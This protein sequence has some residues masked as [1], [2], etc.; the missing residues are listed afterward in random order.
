M[1]VLQMTFSLFF[2]FSLIVLGYSSI[3]TFSENT[4]LD[5]RQVSFTNVTYQAGFQDVGGQFLAWGDYNNDGYQDILVNG[6]RLFE[7]NGPPN[8]DF[9]EVT[10]SVG[11]TGGS[12]G[13]WADWDNDGLLDFYCAGS[14]K[15]YKNN[16]PPD[17]DFTDVTTSSGILK[18]S[19]STGC[20]WGDYDNDGDVDLF[21][22]RGEDGSTGEYFPNSFWR[23]NG[24]GTF[25]NVTVE[26]GVDE[27][28][29]PTYSRGVAWADFN[30]DG[31]LDVYISNYRQLP[32]YLYQ[33]N[34]NGTFTEVAAQ[35]NV[36]DGPPLDEGNLDPYDRA[37]H[38]VGSVW[39]DYDNDGFLDLWV[40]NLNHK[41]ART[42]DDSL[43]YHNDG[44]PNY[45][46]TNMRGS[47]G[48]PVKPYVFPNEGDELFVGCAWG[49]YDNDGDL[50]LYLPQIYDIDYAYSFLYSN[51]GDGT[52]TDVTEEA[53]VQVWDT[54]A[55]CWC[56]YDNDG[57]LDLITSGRD[58]GGNA[59]PHFVHLFRNDGTSGNWL[60]I[61]LKGNGV[62][63]NVAAI[64]TKVI[65][66]QNDGTSQIRTVEGGMGP[67]GMQNSL[68]LEFGLGNYSGNVDIEILWPCGKEQLLEGISTNQVLFITESMADLSISN[69]S[70]DESN[71]I[72]GETVKIFG[73][74]SNTG[75]IPIESVELKFYLDNMDD[76]NQILPTRTVNYIPVGGEGLSYV[77]WD[78]T[79][80]S[81]VHTIFVRAKITKPL[82]GGEIDFANQDI[83]VREE[84]ILPTASISANLTT[85]LKQESV[86]LNG[87]SSSDDTKIVEYYF[88][89]GD[90]TESGWISK[91]TITHIYL[92]AGDFTAS[93]KVKDEDG[94]ESENT[95]EIVIDVRSKPIAFLTAKP[96][97]I[98]KGDSVLF[99]A[100]G[101]SD[102]GGTI[103]YYYFDFG[104][105]MQSDWVSESSIT[106]TYNS[107]G[108]YKAKLTV[109]DDDDDESENTAEVQIE[110]KSRPYALLLAE[111]TVVYVDESVF[112]DGS[113][114][115]AEGSNISYYYFDFGD[116]YKSGWISKSTITHSYSESGV[117]TASLKVRNE[118][119]D[120]SINKAEITITVNELPNQIPTAIID[121]IFPNPCDLGDEV[122]F[123]GFGEDEDG[124]VISYEWRSDIDG[125][126]SNIKSFS[127]RTLSSGTH[128]ISFRVLDDDNAWSQVV[129]LE[130]VVIAPNKKP[131][132]VITT[133]DDGEE[134]FGIIIIAGY[135]DDEDQ[136][137]ERVEIKIDDGKWNFADGTDL[138]SFELDTTTLVDGE[139]TISARSYDGQDYSDEV[140]ISIM[141]EQ[142]KKEEE[143]G[144]NTGL[145]FVLVL[146]AIIAVLILA[147]ALSRSLK[148]K[149]EY[150]EQ[151]RAMQDTQPPRSPGARWN[152]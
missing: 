63:T 47:S 109:R 6:A 145:I 108:F 1:K 79:S 62:T 104:D 3:N 8:W 110:V 16:G 36:A 89:F 78:T 143:R 117:Y 19:Y 95:A 41:D 142:E 86:L 84:N 141:V 85:I 98:Y 81:G 134:V 129:T 147:A 150:P 59:D 40:T 120:E 49:D 94:G 91:G 69:I 75:S 125:I 23:N 90:G 127:T 128:T 96:T 60:H 13:T 111:P 34:G 31:W 53:Q 149:E 50:D 29:N 97:K 152:W 83:D 135:S 144:L 121:F 52:F 39:G 66:T 133:P 32:N 131:T 102:E 74:V 80:I 116:G 17:Y 99:N 64:G 54:Y 70:F 146:L 139:H 18:E 73:K 67:H 2:I 88:D 92:S 61:N 107:G 65:V 76:V 151:Q 57:D 22:I 105:G 132:V 44:P 77:L 130:L 114:S 140:S 5:P 30:C 28:S 9:S 138:W 12:Y 25:T 14:D 103:E 35:K 123:S 71:P 137:V 136:D 26:A 4:P 7:N 113:G 15:L 46:F 10:G 122:T 148:K 101:S 21:K 93:L 45:T 38:S 118:D 82:P 100:S 43:L 115:S 72:M 124:K 87:S 48:I 112:F 56:D 51:N 33:N 20:G 126:L 58:S 55:G 42:S 11:I 27:Y 37:G 106:H 68:A 24:D 119:Q